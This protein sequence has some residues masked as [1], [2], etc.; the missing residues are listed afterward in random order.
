MDSLAVA[1]T[2]G[3]VLG[4]FC[5]RRVIVMAAVFALAQA[6]MPLI[7][8]ALGLGF[9]LL[10]QDFDHWIAFA[11][12]VSLG[13][14]GVVEGLKTHEEPSRLD[15][16]KP[17]T[18]VVLALA[19]SIDALAVGISFSVLRVNI[20]MAVAVIGVAC[21]LI[22]AAG[23]CAGIRFGNRF[24]GRVTLIGG[25]ILILI[26][27]RILYDHIAEIGRADV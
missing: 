2:G 15:P 21:F 11:I 14:K 20:W 26:G 24:G 27:V 22:C 7:G 4:R 9:R 5:K 18:L 10:I 19:T 1:M 17:L 3:V 12:L 13:L 6:V 8:W 23:T 25:V 16:F